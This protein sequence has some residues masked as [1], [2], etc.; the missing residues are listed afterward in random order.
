MLRRQTRRQRQHQ[1]RTRRCL[2]AEWP[3]MCPH[4]R[5]RKRRPHPRSGA[6]ARC[7]RLWR[8][9]QSPR[10]PRSRVPSWRACCSSLGASGPRLARQSCRLRA[11]S[12]IWCVC[13]SET[14]LEAAVEPDGRPTLATSRARRLPLP[15]LVRRTSP[16]ICTQRPRR[17]TTRVSG[18]LL[19][20]RVLGGVCSGTRASSSSRMR[21]RRV[22]SWRPSVRRQEPSLPPC[23]P[24]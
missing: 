7:L 6:R 23:A 24:R 4:P 12:P 10:H 16:R 14:A 8:R 21:L 17:R 3:A 22:T 19:L 20:G 1:L 5:L 9:P 13:A 15:P 11:P 18:S 2:R